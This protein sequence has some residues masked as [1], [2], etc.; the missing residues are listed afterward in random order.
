MSELGYTT[1]NAFAGPKFFFL[2]SIFFFLIGFFSGKGMDVYESFENTRINGVVSQKVIYRRKNLTMPA[3]IFPIIGLI[4]S[5]YLLFN[6]SVS[7]IPLLSG[8]QVTR[9]N[10]WSEYSALPGAGQIN[11]LLTVIA[12]GLGFT[13]AQ[14]ELST[15]KSNVRS[16]HQLSCI[17]I[18]L[19]FACIRFLLGYKVSGIIDIIFAYL[20][21]YI[22]LLFSFKKIAANIYKKLLI[23]G[24]AIVLLAVTSYLFWQ[25]LSGNFSTI[26]QAWQAL[27]ERQFLLSGHMWWAVASDTRVSGNP[28]PSNYSELRSV[29]LQKDIYNPDSGVYGLMQ[30][31]SQS[32]IVEN[33]ISHKV[34][35]SANFFAVSLFYNGIIITVIAIAINAIIL[36]TFLKLFSDDAIH[37]RSLAFV[38]LFRIFQIFSTY[39][40]GSGTLTEFYRINVLLLISIY[41]IVHFVDIST[42]NNDIY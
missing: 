38:I 24:S 36:V 7:G 9:F 4:F 10:Y 13:Y 6:M 2:L 31:Y 8:N 34:R 3:Y 18:A 12:A 25:V 23:Y 30:K 21:G 15:G 27:L 37:Q 35:F 42:N 17:C 5:G 41:F 40:T 28:F 16:K 1:W 19:L 26:G 32:D 29:F 11:N 39:V 20:I 33:Y 22:F 14:T